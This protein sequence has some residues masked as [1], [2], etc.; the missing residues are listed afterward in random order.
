MYKYLCLKVYYAIPITREKRDKRE[1]EKIF[2]FSE[3]IWVVS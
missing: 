2:Y 1:K 3:F